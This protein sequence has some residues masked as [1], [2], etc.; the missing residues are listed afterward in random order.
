M[1]FVAY[2]ALLVG[3]VAHAQ[4]S[5]SS[6]SFQSLSRGD[7]KIAR[8][9]FEAQKPTANGPAPLS[10]NQIADR[11]GSAGW[12]V[13]FKQMKSAGL[14]S[15][16][17][18]GQTVS[19]YEHA[20]AHTSNGTLGAKPVIMTNGGGRAYAEGPGNS[21]SAE[22]D[23]HAHGEAHDAANTTSVTTAGGSTVAAGA[24]VAHGVG[25]SQGG[26]GGLARGHH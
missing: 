2:F 17:N 20:N 1:A 26:G 25:I 3:A 12:G 22:A 4:T 24:G 5:P 19:S 14:L 10:L 21:A 16:K 7:Q 18:L 11:K 9:L 15:A 23:A 8:A 6:G 13:I